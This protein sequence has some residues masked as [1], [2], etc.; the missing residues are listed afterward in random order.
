MRTLMFV[1]ALVGA[2]LGALF[3]EGRPP[4]VG[5]VFQEFPAMSAA[6]FADLRAE[7]AC[8]AREAG[9]D[10]AISL[11]HDREMFFE[12]SVGAEPTIVVDNTT[13]Q[14]LI[15]TFSGGV[16]GLDGLRLLQDAWRSKCDPAQEVW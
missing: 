15:T 1:V 13:G 7:A 10:A 14:L 5:L 9:G 4:G 12:L 2:G 3:G 6:E 16:R 8:V 11:G